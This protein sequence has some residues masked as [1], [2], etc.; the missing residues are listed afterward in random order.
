MQPVRNRREWAGWIVAAL[1]LGAAALLASRPSIDSP[2]GDPI[3]VPIFP[4]EKTAFSGAINTTVNVPS[5]AVSPDGR[6]VVFSAETPVPS[7]D[8]QRF[9]VNTASDPPGSPITVVFNWT[10]LLKN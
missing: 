5:F 3:S 4:A 8:G 10:A 2:P 6:A 7:R 9:I 1:S